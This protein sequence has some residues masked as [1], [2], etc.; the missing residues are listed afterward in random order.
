M[1]VKLFTVSISICRFAPVLLRNNV[2]QE[3]TFRFE[4]SE[5]GNL[6]TQMSNASC[7]Q[8]HTEDCN[9]DEKEEAERPFE[10]LKLSKIR[11][12]QL[13]NQSH[14]ESARMRLS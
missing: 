9:K 6:L 8:N 5:S 12:T 7:V 1:G 2:G 11:L 3:T 13:H 14:M 10:C 4:R